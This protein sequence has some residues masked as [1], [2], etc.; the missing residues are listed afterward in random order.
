[1]LHHAFILTAGLG[2]RARPLTSLRA[3][4]ALP[5]A[6]EPMARRIVRQLVASGVTEIVLNLH[7]RPESIATILG[8]GSDLSAN[9]RYIWERPTL[10]GAAGGP[11]NA[12]PIIGVD[13]FIL[14]NGD[15]LTNLD[16]RA[17]TD[18]HAASGSL[19]TLALVPNRESDRYGG[20][21][22]DS[23]GWVTGFVGRGGTDSYHFI[24]VQVVE[25][26]AFRSLP[27]GEPADSIGGLYDRLVEGRPRAIRGFVC[28]AEFWD[29]GTPMDYWKT[30]MAWAR[31]EHGSDG[32]SGRRVSIDSTSRVTRSIL[33]DDIVIEPFCFLD[34]CIVTDGVR[35]PRGSV[36][37]QTILRRG[38]TMAL[39]ESPLRS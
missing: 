31:R 38:P 22:L 35:V 3:K 9:V 29:I 30:S 25:A 14:V 27:A 2:T 19:V 15:T 33:W 8:D 28:D 11:R 26:D 17:L 7:H 5:V 10:L 12:L 36:Y 13:R 4:A 21:R 6:G 18:A 16:V 32:S 34:E 20:V 23:D 37:R 39:E 24:G 1:M